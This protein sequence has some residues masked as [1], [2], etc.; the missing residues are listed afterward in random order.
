MLTNAIVT[1][2]RR[3]SPLID[4]QIRSAITRRDGNRCCVTGRKATLLDP[5]LV[6][7]ILTVPSGWDTDKVSLLHLVLY[8]RKQ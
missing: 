3:L 7:P 5:L 6:L 4:A 2:S 1:S 8:F